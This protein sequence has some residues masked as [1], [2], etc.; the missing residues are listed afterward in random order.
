MRNLRNVAIIVVIAT[1]VFAL[2][3]GG[4]AADLVGWMATFVLLISISW[5]AGRL[6]RDNRVWLMGLPD[7]D[8]GLL[9]VSLGV[10]VITLCATGRL[11][12][13]AGGTL[14]WIVL[15]AAALSGLFAFWRVVRRY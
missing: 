10:I 1:L 11:M 3:A 5:F 15:L 9:Y 8:R 14:V 6:Y 4:T 2:P 7:A 13:T 12:G